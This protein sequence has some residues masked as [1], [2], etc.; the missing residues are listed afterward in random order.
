MAYIDVD[1]QT[2]R[3]T[4]TWKGF[5]EQTTSG[6]KSLWRY[7][8]AALLGIWGWEPSLL[9][10][11]IVGMEYMGGLNL[12]GWFCFCLLHVRRVGGWIRV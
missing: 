7:D 10:V 8:I 4:V 11:Y 12:G 1:D 5:D 3:N 2:G 6:W 9:Y